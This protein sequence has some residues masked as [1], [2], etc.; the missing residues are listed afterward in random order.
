MLEGAK[1]A[2]LRVLK[3]HHL[4]LRLTVGGRTLEAIGFNMAQGRNVPEFVTLA[5]SLQINDWNGRKSLQLR[6]KDMK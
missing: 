4:K 2:D 6:L 5:F 1:V 3:E